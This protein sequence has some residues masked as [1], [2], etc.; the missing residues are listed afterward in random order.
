MFKQKALIE[1]L[2]NAAIG[3]EV[4]EDDDLYLTD[5]IDFPIWINCNH[6]EEFLFMYSMIP[7]NNIPFEQA[8]AFANDCNTNL[9]MPAFYIMKDEDGD[10]SLRASYYL[11]YNGAP[12][13]RSVIYAVKRFSGAVKASA[14][15]D[16]NDYFLQL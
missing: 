1:F 3:N 10:L 12:T 4:D 5:G 8:I 2:E 6:E 13:P 7:M 9:V 16:D 15:L 11:F 14:E